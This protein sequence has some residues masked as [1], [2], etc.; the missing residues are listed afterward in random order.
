MQN[1]DKYKVL[2]KL[3]SG[4]F[5]SVYL[6]QDPKLHV[7]VA[8][9]VFKVKDATLL[10]QVTSAANDPLS[11][12]KQRF[13]DEAHTLR[14]LSSNPYIVEMYYFDE[15]E[16]GTPYYV[17]PYI[18]HS[19]VDELGKDAFSQGSLEETPKEL[20]PTKIASSKAIHYL[21]QISQALSAVH[22]NGLVHRDIKPANI[23]INSQNQV[24]LSDFGIAKLPLSEQSQ[25]GFGMGSRNYMSPEQQESAKHV[26]AAS[27]V[28]SLG[29]L[30]YRMF[31]G[32][33]PVGRFQDPIEYAP[34]IGIPLNKLILLSLSQDANVRPTNGAEFLSALTTAKAYQESS[35]IGDNQNTSQKIIRHINEGSAQ[36]I[37]PAIEQ[38]IAQNIDQKSDEE[39]LVWSSQ[40]SPL[41]KPELKPLENKIIELLNKQGE[42]K[43]A[44]I[45]LLQVLGDIHHLDKAALTIFIDHIIEQESTYSSQLQSLILWVKTVNKNFQ[46]GQK[47]LSDNDIDILMQAGLS[48]T[49]ETKEQLSAILKTKQQEHSTE[50]STKG[51]TE[52]QIKSVDK[53]L[54]KQLTNLLSHQHIK[55]YLVNNHRPTKLLFFGTLLIVMTV[56]LAIYGQ[57]KNQQQ[58]I[59]ND[60]Q[61][62]IFAKKENTITS[63]EYYL[64]NSSTGNYITEAEKALAGLLQTKEV[65]TTSR[66]SFRQQQ[67]SNAQAQ[68]IKHGFEVTPTGEMDKRTTLAIEAFEKREGLIVTGEVDDV[69]LKKLT[70]SYQQK[71]ALLWKQV[72]AEHSVVAYQRYQTAFPQGLNIHQALNTIKQLN[73]EQE[74][75]NKLKREAGEKQQQDAIA[76][77]INKFLN[78][79]ITLPSGTFT[80]GCIQESECKER[81]TP[82]H[83]V[84]I[85]TFSIMTTEVTFALWDACISSGSC[86]VNPADEGWGRGN[87]PVIGIN[88]FDIVNEF[89]PWLNNETGKVF[90]LPSEAQ[91]E[92]AAK[93]DS[94]SKYAWGNEID[95]QQA[96]FSQFSGICGNDRK[97]ARVK[98]FTPN[99]FGLYDMHGNVWEWTQD[100]WHNSYSFAPTDG[101]T[102]NS[103]DC[104][105]GVIRGGSWLNE[106]NILRSVFRRGY[107]R[108]T[109]SNTKG[110][111]LVIN[112]KGN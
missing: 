44:D 2:K 103:A 29:V 67:I 77:A 23:L 9:K 96:Q 19:L 25:T 76:Q 72:Q 7:Q 109:R 27:D 59:G 32:K 85:K 90:S 26:K 8:I 39:T 12:L 10:S 3:G 94:S 22:E 107:D 71:D 51:G 105:A 17:M 48:T 88:Y 64:Q 4:S 84:S 38:S 99:E 34:E 52:H 55:S 30:A 1:I 58:S 98:S 49:T 82:A 92:Y 45:P 33:L 112:S 13:I 42:I 43:P 68:L 31:T 47:T 62:W 89:I 24:Q 18:Q 66:A 104:D 35:L 11:V 86:K 56:S 15:L 106:G 91:W 74:N 83:T 16:D 40:S 93:A 110:F 87:R 73:N 79:F 102:W 111:R 63:Y 46:A 54:E 21:T 50:H 80:M 60:H 101:S 65:I 70:D 97:T 6:A 78:N 37:V 14:K 5:G 28:Y 100:C 95:C 36:V 61:A 81:E 75:N 108:S 69:L 53:P 41:I 57:Y 20:H